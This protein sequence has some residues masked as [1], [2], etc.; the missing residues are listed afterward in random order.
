MCCLACRL[1]DDNSGL[2]CEH[3]VRAVPIAAEQCRLSRSSAHRGK[4]L[5]FGTRCCPSRRVAQSRSVFVEIGRLPVM[6][7]A[8]STAP[9]RIP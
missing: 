5:P 9:N 4:E 3:T 8:K 6:F 2:G 1:R 7:E